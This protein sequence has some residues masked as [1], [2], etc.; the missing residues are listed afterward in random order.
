M[1][2]YKLDN[3]FGLWRTVDSPTYVNRASLD[4]WFPHYL[5][6]E[7]PQ[8]IIIHG[9][10]RQGKTILRKRHLPEQTAIIIN[11]AYSMTLSDIYTEILRKLDTLHTTALSHKT[12]QE[13]GQGIN[14]S[15]SA[16]VG[17]IKGE[18]GGKADEK[19]SSEIIRSQIP[20][21]HEPS[22]IPFLINRL[23]NSPYRI[24]LDDF[25]FLDK[26]VQQSLALYLKTFYEEGIFFILI[27]VWAEENRLTLYNASLEGRIIEIDVVWTNSELDNVLT[28]GEKALN[29]AFSDEVHKEI[30]EDSHKN[31][32]LL[33]LL[34]RKLCELNGVIGTNAYTISITMDKLQLAR[35]YICRDLRARYN[36][37]FEA[38]FGT[39][40]PPIPQ[41]DTFAR[42][43]QACLLS[44]ETHRLIGGINATQL[45][46]WILLIDRNTLI[47]IQDIDIALS[48][49]NRVQEERG[50]QSPIFFYSNQR[51]LL[52]IVEPELL[53]Y[54][55]HRLALFPWESLTDQPPSIID[56]KANQ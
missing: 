48:K 17:L 55:K 41:M 23:R 30:I 22:S 8:H 51:N 42:I 2:N 26:E 47:T 40:P 52:H 38:F 33:Q 18:L 31:V 54:M 45:L 49:I 43:I 14:A 12:T 7:A 56:P 29:I 19:T 27:G 46:A 15:L 4:E 39:A 36:G 32:G 50:V 9:P 13:G 25:H 44:K 34:A 21:D 6:S 37:F 11:C 1:T 16:N 10:S 3:V 28:Q 53:F 35:E 20:I 5:A 24:V